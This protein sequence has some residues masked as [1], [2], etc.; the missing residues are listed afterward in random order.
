[1]TSTRRYEVSSVGD[2]HQVAFHT[3]ADAVGWCLSVQSSLLTAAWPPVLEEHANTRLRCMPP[4]P[5]M[6]LALVKPSG[7]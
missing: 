6:H 5:G 2:H 3:P 7:T 1:M 4:G